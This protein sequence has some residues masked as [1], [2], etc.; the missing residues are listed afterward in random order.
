MRVAA[1]RWV[2]HE[3]GAWRHLGAELAGTHGKPCLTGDGDLL[4]GSTTELALANALENALSG[5]FIGFREA[6]L[7]FA[8]GRLVPSPDLLLLL[9]TGPLGQWTAAGPF[10][11][12]VPPGFEFFVHVWIQGPAGPFGLAGSNAVSATTP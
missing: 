6:Q 12:G 8:G 7:P 5:L 2:C 1:A 3:R 4:A 10:P 11:A 9:P